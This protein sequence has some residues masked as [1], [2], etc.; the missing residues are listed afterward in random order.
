MASCG[1]QEKKANNKDS[2]MHPALVNP[3][4]KAYTD[5]IAQDT[6][7]ASLYFQRAEK[8]NQLGLPELTKT[9][10]ETAVRLDPKNQNYRESLANL[11]ID[12][13][14]AKEAL[15]QVEVLKK[16]SPT[17]TN[18]ILM[19]AEALVSDKK[20][21]EANTIIENLLIA[22]PNHPYV[23]LDAAKIKAAA[24]DTLTALK[25]ARN[26]AKTAPTYYDGVYELADLLAETKNPEAIIWYNKLYKMDSLNAYP[27]YDIASY[28]TK[29]GDNALAKSYF[30]KAIMVD[31][32]FVNAYLDY[33]K[34]LLSED[35]IS[36]ADRQFQLATEV[37]PAN[38]DAYY[39][40]GMI[41]LKKNNKAL[42]KNF[43]EQA[44]IF[45]GKHQEARKE[46][47]KIK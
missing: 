18:Y 42:A 3:V 26:L 6:T 30:I 40:K 10:L 41:Y 2:Q 23:L 34:I 27:F 16:M 21:D 36:K 1:Q 32:D 25:H 31:K 39:Y 37:S 29:T 14:Y 38:A 47:E 4:V 15:A 8:L 5:A 17:D 7:N 11:L 9:D 13:G 20:I 28:Y 22:A 45:N 44:L 33:G 35:S 43:F 19:E 12:N 46:Y 24:K